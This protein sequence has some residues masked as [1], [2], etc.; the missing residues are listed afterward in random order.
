MA[1]CVAHDGA[2]RCLPAPCRHS[3]RRHAGHCDACMRH[4]GHL[5]AARSGVRCP[6]PL[7][8]MP[9][10]CPHRVPLPA[11]S[12]PASSLAAHRSNA[13]RVP[14]IK[15]LLWVEIRGDVRAMFAEYL[16]DL[17]ANLERRR[18]SK[19]AVMVSSS[20][21]GAKASWTRR[22]IARACRRPK[23]GIARACRRPTRYARATADLSATEDD[24][25]DRVADFLVSSESLVARW[26]GTARYGP[27]DQCSPQRGSRA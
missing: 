22:G 27:Q 10:L 17:D 12:A 11:S 3:Q 4:A 5:P 18:A 19:P 1:P 21:R 6:P 7:R 16:T 25:V 23:Y 2:L 15:S 14:S 8:C 13:R 9:P 24:R 26:S 20:S